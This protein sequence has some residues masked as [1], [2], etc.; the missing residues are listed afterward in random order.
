MLTKQ[1]NKKMAFTS[2]PYS[3]FRTTNCH[4]KPP[5]IGPNKSRL[6]TLRINHQNGCKFE[7]QEICSTNIRRSFNS[8]TTKLKSTTFNR[9][10][11]L[12]E[13]PNSPNSPNSSRTSVESI[14]LKY[15]NFGSGFNST[16][17]NQFNLNSRGSQKRSFNISAS[18]NKPSI[19]QISKKTLVESSTQQKVVVKKTK[20]LLNQRKENLLPYSK[21]FPSG[22]PFEDEFYRK[23]RSYSGTP[24]SNFSNYSQSFYDK[25]NYED[26]F[27]RKPSNEPLYVDFSKSLPNSNSNFNQQKNGLCKF[28][29]M[30]NGNYV[31]VR[32]Q[33]KIYVAV[34]SWVPKCNRV[35]YKASILEPTNGN[36]VYVF[37]HF[38]LFYLLF[39]LFALLKIFEIDFKLIFDIKK[40]FKINL[41]CWDNDYPVLQ[42]TEIH[43]IVHDNIYP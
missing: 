27:L 31:I 24:L 30:R 26:E 13:K 38:L 34:A 7:E 9:K 23:N 37:F 4:S 10:T 19:N 33:P 3:S 6:P 11:K 42:Y 22:L 17:N 21:N 35:A 5:I 1:T 28:E 36:I 16:G 12:D 40:L 14:V 25:N 29:S 8:S 41:I 2:R 39:Q 32:D 18:T 20:E 15:G 43:F